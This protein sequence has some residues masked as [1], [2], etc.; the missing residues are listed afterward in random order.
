MR[1]GRGLTAQ[2]TSTGPDRAA[3]QDWEL[4]N[5]SGAVN[6]VVEHN[7]VEQSFDSKN[8]CVLI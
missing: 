6:G 7:A 3:N 1:A 5:Q 8:K 4:C 2:E